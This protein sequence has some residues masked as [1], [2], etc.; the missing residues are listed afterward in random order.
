MELADLQ[1]F[2]DW[3]RD[4]DGRLHDSVCRGAYARHELGWQPNL[5]LKPPV[6]TDW[7][8]TRD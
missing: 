4:F 2:T 7:S 6:S 5:T 3:H 1:H 8:A